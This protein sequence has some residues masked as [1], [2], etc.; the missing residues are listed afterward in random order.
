MSPMMRRIRWPCGDL[1]VRH[2]AAATI[3]AV[4]FAALP[5]WTPAQTPVQTPL[6]RPDDEAVRAVETEGRRIASYHEAVEKARERLRQQDPALA[7]G[8]RVVVV[9][10]AGAWH[11]VLMRRDDSHPESKAMVMAADA[12]FQPKAGEI[13]SF[14][15]YT[16]PKP[17]PPDAQA[18]LR[19]IETARAGAQNQPGLAR[20]PFEESVFREKGGSFTVVLHSKPDVAGTVKFGAD[21]LARVGSDGAQLVEIKPLHD[22]TVAVKVPA[23]EGAEPG[24]HTHTSGD[25]PT[26]TDVAL[27]IEHPTLAPHLV[28][29]PHWMFR[30]EADGGLTW[31]GPNEVP[32]VAPGGGR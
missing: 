10:R 16:P 23:K 18:A 30:I 5:A 27:V 31:L 29:T 28:L 2:R 13:V 12:V 21:L 14:Q 32:P 8:A 9:E 4:L 7:E 25:L 1:R 3:V 11:V 20:P 24:L 26:A 15:A 19:A 22:V 6:S 17:A